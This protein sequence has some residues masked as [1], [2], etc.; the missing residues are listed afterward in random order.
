MDE[1]MKKDYT[2]CYIA[3]L[4][5]LGFKNMIGKC[6]CEELLD[7]FK[8]MNNPL[9]SIQVGDDAGNMYD[10]PA[11]NQIKIKVMSDSI[12]FFIDSSLQDAL[13]CLLSCC[14]I[15]QAKL[16]RR[17]VPIMVRGAIVLGEIYSDG[18][19]IFGSGMTEAYLLEEGNAKYP[20]IIITKSTLMK[21]LEN[22][23]RHSIK[24]HLEQ[25]VYCDTD[26]YYAANWLNFIFDIG[27]NKEKETFETCYHK[28][29]DYID[30][31]LSLET[32]LS[33]R[34]KYLYLDNKLNEYYR[35]AGGNNEHQR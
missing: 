28:L 29:S 19:I 18:D 6:T 21:G 22:I 30:S 7:V 5:I 8:D 31:V 4:D 9:K 26:K 20:R 15:F 12:C 33:I 11:V 2:K 23:S 32:S 14:A 34:E 13:F 16:L 10:I 25:Y 27:V 35:K 1:N 3:F 17:T 24:N